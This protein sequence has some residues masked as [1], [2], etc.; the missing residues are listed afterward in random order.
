M[1]TNLRAA[2]FWPQLHMTVEGYRGGYPSISHMR[3]LLHPITLNLCAKKVVWYPVHE[4]CVVF[5]RTT[6]K[7][8]R[9]DWKILNMYPCW[10]RTN[11]SMRASIFLGD[12]D[13]KW[14]HFFV[15]S[16][17]LDRCCR[18]G[19]SSSS[20]FSKTH[21]WICTKVNQMSSCH[22]A[23]LLASNWATKEFQHNLICDYFGSPTNQST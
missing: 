14:I 3:S 8:G 16:S 19:R 23:V 21:D 18:W 5:P 17:V 1:Q 20:Q 12:S 15:R 22:S 13:S 7:F 4:E 11:E 9:F 6:S 10:N 2:R